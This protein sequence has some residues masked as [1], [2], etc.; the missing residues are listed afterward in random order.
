MK[1]DE[2]LLSFLQHSGSVYNILIDLEGNYLYSNELYKKI[3]FKPD[4]DIQ[5]SNFTSS[6]IGE[7]V[8]VFKDARS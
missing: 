2:N 7:D 6:L 3:F 5:D 8:A 4:T 1:S